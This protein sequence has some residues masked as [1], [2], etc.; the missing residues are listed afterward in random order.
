MTSRYSGE[1]RPT[2]KEVARLAGVAPAS[3]SR[4]LND[5]PDVSPDMRARVTHAAEQLGY[6]PDF[7]AKSLRHGVTR[8]VGYVVRDISIPL[9]AGVMKGAEEKFE[10]AGYSIL[11]MNS[12]RDPERDARHIRFLRKRQVDGLLLC[13]Q[14]ETHPQT[15]AALRDVGAPLVLI[16]RELENIPA[17]VLRSDHF[18]GVNAAASA[19]LALG[20]RRIAMLAGPL[21]AWASRERIRGFLASHDAAGLRADPKLLPIGGFDQ[22]SAKARMSALLDLP[23]PPTAVIAGGHQLGEGVLIVL[24]SLNLQPGSDISLVICDDND[25]LP[26][27]NP[28]ISVVSRDAMAMGRLAAELLVERLRDPA[29]P[30]RLEVLPTQYVER[31]SCQPPS[32]RLESVLRRGR[33]GASAT[34]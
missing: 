14:S 7:I 11:L 23:A 20:H 34:R 9:F 28:P 17:S 25:L 19:L 4:T 10:S 5:H 24:N 12:L 3:V 27:M 26:L 13:L 33:N 15:L 6:E 31:G 18:H 2:I 8:S 30:P 22:E 16:D 32:S 21:D 1:Q 29:K